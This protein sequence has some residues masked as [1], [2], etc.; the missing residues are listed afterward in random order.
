MAFRR[1]GETALL[2]S[3]A[4]CGTSTPVPE[5]AANVRVAFSPVTGQHVDTGLTVA[6]L[7]EAAIARSDNTG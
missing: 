3:G 1:T 4:A 5:K 7:C 6:Q 2:L